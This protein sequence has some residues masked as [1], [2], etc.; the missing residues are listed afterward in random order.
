MALTADG[1][2]A[3]MDDGNE[4]VFYAALGSGTTSGTENSAARVALTLG[5]PSTASPSV[6][7]V[8]NV[9]LNF[10]GTPAASV[11]NVLL[12]SA[13]S[14]GTFYG[15]KALTGDSAYNAGGNYSITALTF[16]ATAT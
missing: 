1:L 16:T 8:T 5:T 11:T 12:F 3:L 6:I 7:T 2:K 10:T 13:S 4:A 9:P 14:G 15:N